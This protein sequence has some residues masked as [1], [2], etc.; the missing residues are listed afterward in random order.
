MSRPRWSGLLVL[1]A[2]L[3]GAL[4]PT[5][6]QPPSRGAYGEPPEHISHYL[7]DDLPGV[8]DA[9]QLLTN[10]LNK[11]LLQKLLAEKGVR[12]LVKE[13]VT[14]M[15]NKGPYTKMLPDDKI[16]ELVKKLLEQGMPNN[17]GALD[18]AATVEKLQRLL[19]NKEMLGDKVLRGKNDELNELL[20]KLAGPM[21]NAIKHN[22]ESFL[23]AP[24]LLDEK[25]RGQMLP[26]PSVPS[27][28]ESAS[29]PSEPSRGD[30]LTDIITRQLNRLAD[31]LDKM[32]HGNESS[33]LR[34]AIS[35]FNRYGFRNSTF[36]LDKIDAGRLDALGRMLR[37]LSSEKPSSFK[38]GPLPRPTWLPKLPSLPRVNIPSVGSSSWPGSASPSSWSLDSLGTGLLWVCVLVLFG[39]LLWTS[40]TWLRADRIGGKE[41]AWRLGAW[42]V[43]PAHVT[44]RGDLVRAFEHLALLI[45]GPTARAC[46]HHDL[47]NRLSQQGEV[48]V[49]ERREAA[50]RLAALYEQARYAPEQAHADVPLPESEQAIARQALCLLAGVT[51]A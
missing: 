31:D 49:P 30:R 10:R 37:S 17:L 21:I 11:M 24:L 19:Q 18:N 42:P 33:A 20:L 40:G 25:S 26:P 15:M 46:H 14:E 41:S 27:A 39:F 29:L 43:A 32:D 13:K 22:P 45:L 51:P 5:Q 3:L 50:E 35:R 44:T 12:D 7:P 1:G 8:G 47:A 38:L 6:A 9:E 23:K 4:S 48:L 16:N 36:D 34:D 2:L 28:P